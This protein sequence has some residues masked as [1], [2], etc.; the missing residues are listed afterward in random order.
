MRTRVIRT[1]FVSIAAATAIATA[2]EPSPVDS[3]NCD[4]MMAEL[5]AAGQQMSARLDPEFAREAQAMYNESQ[6]GAAGAVATGVGMGL[7]CMIPG[8]GMLCA[9]GQQAQMAGMQGKTQE[10]IERMQAQ[11]A[12][13]QEAMAGLD[14]ERLEQLS[15]RF[16]SEKCPVPQ[17]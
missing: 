2:A 1:F 13:M 15:T 6:A 7:A 5:T 10:N 16:E 3:M 12:R 17:N 11:M 8:V 4:Q 14:M 9:I